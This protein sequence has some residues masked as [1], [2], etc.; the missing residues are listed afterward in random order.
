M[1]EQ[2]KHAW[3]VSR[4]YI[5]AYNDDPTFRLTPIDFG[6]QLNGNG[7]KM[8]IKWFE[9][10]QVPMELAECNGNV[11][12]ETDEDDEE[13]EDDYIFDNEFALLALCQ[14]NWLPL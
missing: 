11:N 14:M 1:I 4:L 7:N 8:K 6:C 5:N 9:G 3:Y 2:T 10:E 12:D 13:E